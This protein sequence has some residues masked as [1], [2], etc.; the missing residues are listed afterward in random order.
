VFNTPIIEVAIGLIFIFSLLAI[1]VTQINTFFSN[2]LKIRA[3]QLKDGL[4][5]LILDDQLKA[6]IM[7][8]PLINLIKKPEADASLQISPQAAETV[9]SKKAEL[10]NVTY[11]SPATF[12][13]ALVTTLIARSGGDIYKPLEDA[14]TTVQDQAIR[15][16]LTT[17]LQHLQ[18]DLSADRAAALENAIVQAP[19]NRLLLQAFYPLNATLAASRYQPSEI[20]LLLNGVSKIEN[21]AFRE[22]M[23]LV[24]ATARNLDEARLKLESWFNDGMER[25]SNLFQ[26]RMQYWSL[27][28]AFLLALIFN[29]DTLYIGRELWQD[30][31]LRQQVLAIAR[32]TD[33]RMV[34]QPVP[35]DARGVTVPEGVTIP[36]ADLEMSPQAADEAGE[37]TLDETL[38]ELSAD[39]DDIGTTVQKILEL[40]LPI[41]WEYVEITPDLVA[42]NQQLALPDPRINTRNLYNLA[43]GDLGMILQKI[44][45][46]LATTI[47]AAQGAPF[48]FDLL[49][50]IARGRATGSVS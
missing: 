19:N 36:P 30:Q 39:A 34:T 47:A 38:T 15:D 6:E 20:T 4:S 1:L 48:W 31:D 44:L 35:A 16:N 25:A 5:R 43:R 7:V 26:R 11:I 18:Y 50:R 23:G 29:V 2:I 32:R 24:L 45:G 8:H 37:R 3:K 40:Q 42:L 10:N 49:N 33:P 46:I 13:E 12:V 28:S 21:P 41:G 14:I 22:A 9:N 27:L 17:L